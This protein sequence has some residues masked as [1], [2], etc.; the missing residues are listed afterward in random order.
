MSKLS[1]KN[2]KEIAIYNLNILYHIPARLKAIHHYLKNQSL[3]ET[4]YK[5][6]NFAKNIN[7]IIDNH[8]YVLLIDT[9]RLT[10][11]IRQK[12]SGKS[13]SNRYIN[14]LSAMGL[15]N[16]V[17][18]NP[19]KDILLD[20]NRNF[21]SHSKYKR[22]INV[23]SFKRYTQDELD[24]IEQRSQQLLSKGVT[25]GNISFNYLCMNN[26][27][28]IAVEVYYAN[29]RNSPEIKK[30]EAKEVLN[31]LDT[32]IDTYGYASRSM[33][34]ENSTLP[35]KEID[36]VIALLKPTLEASYIFKPPSKEQILSFNLPS[37]A[38]IYLQREQ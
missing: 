13:T 10:Y 32:L 31:I 7:I 30:M 29:N 26:C 15:L 1:I 18:Q 17:Y 11:K 3:K 36:K 9:S 12:I 34:K 35:D 27:Y 2:G 16:K 20:A 28:E 8:R 25:T 6:F 5:I 22:A 4:L 37:K 23:F 14:L 38:F 33:I 24:R 19:Q 21:L